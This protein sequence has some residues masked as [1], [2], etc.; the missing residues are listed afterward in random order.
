[1]EGALAQEGLHTLER[2]SEG[3]WAALVMGKDA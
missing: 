2:M 3:V 1:V